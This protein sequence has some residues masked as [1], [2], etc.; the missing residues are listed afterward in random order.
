MR[1]VVAYE[2]LSLDGVAERPD[3]FITDFD[4]PMR[5]NLRRVIAAE[6]AV[7]LGGRT[8]DDWAGFWPTSD[9]E[10]LA[11]FI[12]GVQKF[13]V[14]SML[15]EQERTPTVVVE[16]GIGDFVTELKQQPAATSG[17]TGASR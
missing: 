11:S 12:N 17:S 9:I 15:L 3:E 10:R 1:K 14:T 13:A 4:D 2:L 6:D 7:L 5:E 8:Y 16:G